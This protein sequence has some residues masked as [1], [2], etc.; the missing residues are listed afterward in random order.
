MLFVGN[1][2]S[3]SGGVAAEVVSVLV[4]VENEENEVGE[5]DYS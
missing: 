1:F 3:G 5:S 4:G 2:A